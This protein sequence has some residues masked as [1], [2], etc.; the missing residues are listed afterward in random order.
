MCL[1]YLLYVKICSQ[2]QKKKLIRTHKQSHTKKSQIE[3][4]FENYTMKCFE[5]IKNGKIE[6]EIEIFFGIKKFFL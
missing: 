6:N 5:F 4:R 1:K 3:T 2:N